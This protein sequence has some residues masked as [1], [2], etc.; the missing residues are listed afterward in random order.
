[1]RPF[2]SFNGG[3]VPSDILILPEC[4]LLCAESI[5]LRN[6]LG[7]SHHDD[8]KHFPLKPTGECDLDI[9]FL[10]HYRI[11]DSSCCIWLHGQLNWMLDEPSFVW[12]ADNS[13]C[14]VKL[15]GLFTFLVQSRHQL[16][17]IYGGER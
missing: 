13:F 12:E 11:N 17:R 14:R 7:T 4:L 15:F 10:H 8:S 9:L 16:Q 6:L 3:R 1:M 5:G 2:S